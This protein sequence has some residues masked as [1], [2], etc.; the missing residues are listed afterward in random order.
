[1]NQN[2]LDK[3]FE[4]ANE[5]LQ[6]RFI[7]RVFTETGKDVDQAQSKFMAS[8]GFENAEWYSG[9]SFSST[10]NS[11]DMEFLKMH[12][13][14]DMKTITGPTGKH[15]KKNYPIY[16]RIIWGH[17]NNVIREMQFG[18]TDAVKAELSKLGD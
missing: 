4:T 8:R 5:I 15:N 3:R 11:L 13:F 7:R 18:F 9:R 16:N 17:Y 2:L 14:V 10:D 1:M 12:R 6:N